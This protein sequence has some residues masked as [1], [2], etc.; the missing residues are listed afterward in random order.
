MVTIMRKMAAACV[1]F[2]DESV[3]YARNGFPP[4]KKYSSK[5]KDAGLCDKMFI[6]YG[7][8]SSFWC[9]VRV[10]IISESKKRTLFHPQ[11]G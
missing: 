5:P 2:D 9:I 1:K 3:H 7:S 4:R 10:T 6:S 8:T 11:V